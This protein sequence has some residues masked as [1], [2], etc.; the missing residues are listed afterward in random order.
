MAEIKR[1]GEFF[2]RV[3]LTLM[4]VALILK[5]YP[6]YSVY[7]AVWVYHSKIQTPCNISHV[8]SKFLECQ[9]LWYCGKLYPRVYL[10]KIIVETFSSALK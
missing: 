2:S 5:V 10:K 1:A 9:C 4:A 7:T 3:V 6:V 8:L